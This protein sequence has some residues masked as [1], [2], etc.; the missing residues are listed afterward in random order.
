MQRE[1]QR[2]NCTVLHCRNEGNVYEISRFEIIVGP[3]RKADFLLL[4]FYPA[5]LTIVSLR[6]SVPFKHLPFYHCAAACSGTSKL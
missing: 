6:C 5:V 4:S 1:P 2:C 3:I